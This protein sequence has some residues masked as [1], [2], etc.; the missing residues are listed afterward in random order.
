MR[1]CFCP[2]LSLAAG[3]HNYQLLPNLTYDQALGLQL[4]TYLPR[5]RASTTSHGRLGSR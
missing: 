2:L 3:A 1:A 5:T 4:D